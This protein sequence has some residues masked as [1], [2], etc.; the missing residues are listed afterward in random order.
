MRIGRVEKQLLLFRRTWAGVSFAGWRVL[1]TFIK[2]NGVFVCKRIPTTSS[3]SSM[4]KFI[5][6]F[7]TCAS[8]LQRYLT[9]KLEFNIITNYVKRYYEHR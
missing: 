2:R 1:E 4:L 6:V 7:L 8:K 9:T 5:K 3:S